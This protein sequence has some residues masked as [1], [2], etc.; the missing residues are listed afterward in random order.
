MVWVHGYHTSC[1]IEISSNNTTAYGRKKC[2]HGRD[3][4]S[5]LELILN[6]PTQRGTISD[7]TQLLRLTIIMNANNTQPHLTHSPLFQ[8]PP[9]HWRTIHSDAAIDFI[10]GTVLRSYLINSTRLLSLPS[11]VLFSS[12][13]GTDDALATH[14]KSHVPWRQKYSL[15]ADFSILW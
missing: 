7:F 5:C 13:S 8:T 6:N 9:L 14:S 1:F 11:G 15:P 12:Y 3:Y 4:L 10:T 2:F